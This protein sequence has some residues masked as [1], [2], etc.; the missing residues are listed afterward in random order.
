MNNQN[1]SLL[2]FWAKTS[3]D[4]EKENAYHPLICHLIDV[5][6]VTQELWDTVLSIAEQNRIADSLGLK[7]DLVLA[8]KVV[9]FIA[10]L[11]D[12]GKCSPP[13]TLRGHNDSDNNQTKRLLK[14]YEDTGFYENWARPAKDA[15]HGYVT[16]YELPDILIGEFGFASQIS[17]KISTLIGG[18]HGIFPN[19]R[20]I[21]ELESEKLRGNECWRKARIELAAK[22]A[23]VLEIS[24]PISFTN[25]P[26]LTNADVMILAGLVSVADWIGSNTEFFVCEIDDSTKSDFIINL[27]AYK[28]KSQT[29]ARESLKSLGWILPNDEAL[30]LTSND[31]NLSEQENFKKLFPFIK[32]R[33]HLQDM[34]IEI[35]KELDQ[36]GIVI[37]EAPTGEGKTEAAMYLADAWNKK[38]KLNGYYFA[39]PTQATSNQM[40]GRVN[41]F[42]TNSFPNQN[43]QNQ[44]LHG[45]AALSA[46]F[47]T[48][49]ENY[50]QFIKNISD[51]ECV[52]DSCT[53][54]VVAAEWFTYKK[55][56][57][58]A[59]FGVGTIDQALLAV[60]QTKH[61][62]VRLFGLA[63]KTIIIDEVHAYDAYMSTILEH[64][65]EWLAAL[66]SPV[67]LLS[68]TLPSQ[69]KNRLIK[70]YQ[71]GLGIKSCEFEN[72][73][74]PRI[75]YAVGETVKIRELE[76]SDK[77]KRTIDL[78]KID[79][80]FIERLKEELKDDGGC[81]AIICNTVARSQAIFDLLSK[82]KFF[83]GNDEIDGLPKV[84]LL[85]SRF[86]YLE[87][88]DR[89]DNCLERFGKP[90]KNDESPKRPKLA[91]LVSTQIIEQ[92]L[93]LDFDLMITELAPI[94]LLLQRA[95]RL[96]RH[97]RDDRPQNFRDNPNLWIIKP[98]NNENEMPDF[99]K[100]RYVY[101]EHILLRTWLKIKEIEKIKVPDEIE[102]LI[103]TVYGK[104]QERLDDKFLNFW[105]ETKAE[106]S[107]KL[108]KKKRKAETALIARS[109]DSDLFN[110]VVL[111]LDEDNPDVH[112]SLQAFTRNVE[113]PTVSIVILKHDENFT[114]NSPVEKLLM[115]EAKISS[116][117][118]TN[119]ILEDEKLKPNEWKTSAHLRNH[120]LLKLDENNEI[121]IGKYII[122]LDESLGICIDKKEKTQ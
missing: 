102:E 120:K 27:N 68:A 59:P 67:I 42:L 74:Y 37:V 18:H 72:G 69:K 58:L 26:D 31:Q 33:R 112:K 63:N 73:T 121:K 15:P 114:V 43:I 54:S 101:D 89:E 4:K 97:E 79:E 64:L 2:K 6:A 21:N 76:T 115:R 14:L 35:G 19:D 111:D 104:D 93:D 87:R 65:L 100:S 61:V 16:A 109:D 51:D 99:G 57:L 5:A 56:G 24:K 1:N 71:K 82:D 81:V 9:S 29:Q 96:Q 118:I 55:R 8:G 86:R 32:S 62:F 91:V 48:L 22:L 36:P 13:F 95:G 47:K 107:E 49:K 23:E 119:A 25:D 53:P 40:F 3:H 7:N 28:Q 84:N 94:D 38:L 110:N 92:S 17:Y 80:N 50:R 98:Q 12:L 77:N 113:L 60:L 45:H 39:L 122:K 106:M 66:G 108:R 105:N 11:H 20:R 90:D 117:G 46:E 34:A 83:Q 52:G 78:K 116:F 30:K 41:K 85:H 44:L 75:S 70:S 10:G 103:E 88:K